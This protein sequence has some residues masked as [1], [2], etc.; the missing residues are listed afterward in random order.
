MRKIFRNF[1][2]FFL[3]K[4]YALTVCNASHECFQIVR[5]HDATL[6]KRAEFNQSVVGTTAVTVPVPYSKV[7][8][9]TELLS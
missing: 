2:I 1:I 6:Q 5:S 3:D 9:P 8:K 7:P 4:H